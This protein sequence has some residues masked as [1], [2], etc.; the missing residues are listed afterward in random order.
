MSSVRTIS[1]RD[2]NQKFAELLRAVGAGA[3]FL[4]TRRGRPVARIVSASDDGTRALTREQEAALERT[5]K[6]LA[7]G[8]ALGGGRIDRVG[9]HDR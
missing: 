2:A 8:W 4:V 3:E 1:A 7:E 6:R 9:L 5:L